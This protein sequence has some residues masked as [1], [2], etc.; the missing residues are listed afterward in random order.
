MKSNS[1]QK[2]R[3]ILS[4]VPKKKLMIFIDG[5]NLLHASW[6]YG[7]LI[8]Q[9][10]YGV[11][12]ILVRD[13]LTS[14]KSDCDLVRAYYYGSED[15]SNPNFAGQRAFHDKLRYAGM[16]ATIK[17]IR[18]YDEKKKEKGVDVA[19]ATDLVYFGLRRFYDVAIIV[20]GDSD[21]AGAIER[22]KDT[23]ATIRME[24]SQFRNAMG[25]ELLK[26][27]DYFHP[28]DDVAKKIRWERKKRQ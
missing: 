9:P 7:R 13:V 5:S 6:E 15:P 17:K 26:V 11:S 20:S 14:M 12:P 19:L 4:I 28:L 24:I 16:T 27:C 21:L 22:V 2:R 3:K 18:I 10:N 23:E 1:F 25:N 8:K